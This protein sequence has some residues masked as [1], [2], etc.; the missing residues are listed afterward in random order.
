MTLADDPVALVKQANDIVDVIGEYI[1]LTRKGRTYKGLCPFHDD[2]NPSLDVD[3]ARQ[4]FR[5]WACGK[6]GDVITFVQEYERLDFRGALELLARR[7][8]IPLP[9]RSSDNSLKLQLFDIMK[10]AEEQYH[11][12][13]KHAREAERARQYLRQRGIQDKTVDDFVLGFAPP[14][15]DWLVRKARAKGY[16]LD[17]L[18]QLGLVAANREKGSWYDRFRDRVIFPIRDVKGRTVAFGGRILPDSPSA[19]EAPK[20]Y[21]S[22]DTPLFSKSEH[23]FGLDRARD[24]IHD[25]GFL[26]IVEG[27]TDV[28][29][30]HQLGVLHVAATLGTALNSRHL[31]L[32]RRYA[33]RVVLV[34]DADAGGR[35]GVD[36]ALELFFSHEIDLHIAY[37]PEGLDPCDFL[38]KQGAQAFEQM[39]QQAEDALDCKLKQ[40]WQPERLTTLEQKRQAVEGILQVLAAAPPLVGQSVALRRELFIGRLA[41]RTGIREEALWSWLADAWRR[42]TRPSAQKTAA[43]VSRRPAPRLE[44]ELIAL[45]LV[46][47]DR[48][49][50][51]R[52]LIQPDDLSHPGLRRVLQELYALYDRGETVTTD[53]VRTRLADRP[54]LAD[55]LLRLEALAQAHPRRG[56][57]WQQVHDAW[58]ERKTRPHRQDIKERLGAVPASG[59]VPVELLRRLQ[60]LARGKSSV[61]SRRDVQPTSGNDPSSAG[62][63]PDKESADGETG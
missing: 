21:N 49:A 11:S 16:P 58:V 59:P 14:D 51:A 27:Y 2:H 36:Q 19:N 26:A 32:L 34:F 53:S 13:L 23:L 6:F 1:N 25:K 40:V 62:P 5:C 33:P 38:L 4:R 47:P 15:R 3:P 30:A 61:A 57:W 35:R 17:L 18:E 43:A 31:R 28:L 55:A 22:T 60:N 8:R 50:E 29:M 54:A 42:R 45:L 41:A 9:S 56:E 37:L 48:I 63:L 7:A 24:A 46:E 10:W 52:Q 20:Y 12:H 39:L 44:K